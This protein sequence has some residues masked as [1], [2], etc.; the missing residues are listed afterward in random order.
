MAQEAKKGQSFQVYVHGKG[1]ILPAGSSLPAYGFPFVVNE[2]GALVLEVSATELEEDAGGLKALLDAG[3][4][5][6][7]EGTQ[8]QDDT[9]KKTLRALYARQEG[10]PADPK[11][12]IPKLRRELGV[13]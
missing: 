4:V 11:W 1:S 6:K 2:G 8:D 7:V 13:A 9:V 3:K 12:G 10:K 5:V